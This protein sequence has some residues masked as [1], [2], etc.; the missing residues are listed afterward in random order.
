MHIEGIPGTVVAIIEKRDDF[1]LFFFSSL[2]RIL[3]ETGWCVRG[4]VVK[5]RRIQSKEEGE[6]KSTD[7]TGYLPY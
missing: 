3:F 5:H 1:G 7:I 6:S 2:P 4:G